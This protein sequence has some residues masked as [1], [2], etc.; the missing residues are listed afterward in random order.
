[1]NW[2]KSPRP[3]YTSISPLSTGGDC[4]NVGCVPSKALLKCAKVA[5]E[6]RHAAQFGVTISGTVTVDFAKVMER[7]RKLR[8]DISKVRALYSELNGTYGK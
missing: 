1:M 6:V 3:G 5:H 8:A 7:M 2:C 4:L